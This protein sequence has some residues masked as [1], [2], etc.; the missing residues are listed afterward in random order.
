MQNINGRKLQQNTKS[1]LDTTT[2]KMNACDEEKEA[3]LA[4]RFQPIVVG[5]PNEEEAVSILR[6]LKERYESNQ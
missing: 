3:A 6:G 4:R 2:I 5:E 1:L